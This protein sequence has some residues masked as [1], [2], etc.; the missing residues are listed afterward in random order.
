[1]KL[2]GSSKC[3]KGFL[4]SCILWN[5]TANRQYHDTFTEFLMSETYRSAKNLHVKESTINFK[6]SVI[7]V[8]LKSY[9]KSQVHV[10]W[11]VRKNLKYLTKRDC[12]CTQIWAKN[13]YLLNRDGRGEQVVVSLWVYSHSSEVINI[14]C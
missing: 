10:V 8:I 13:R 14:T 7:L 3:Y 4:N 9:I 1:M 11:Y 5:N 2:D 12:F 6:T